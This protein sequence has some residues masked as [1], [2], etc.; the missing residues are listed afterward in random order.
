MNKISKVFAKKYFDLNKAIDK[1]YIDNGIGCLAV[2]IT[3]FNDVISRY[4]G[5]GYECLNYE[6]Y[7]YLDRNIQYIPDNVP[8]LLQVYGCK[9][10]QKQKAIII[11]NVREHYQYKLGE[12][13]ESNNNTVRKNVIFFALAIVFLFLFIALEDNEM[14]SSFLNLVFWFYGSSVVTF[15]AVDVRRARK[16]R[17]RAGQIANMYITIDE[18][19]NSNPITEED[20]RIIYEYLREVE[21]KEQEKN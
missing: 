19:Y 15:F 6:F 9:L 21:A 20:K 1:S 18:K 12:V 10:T 3:K 5:E 2:K 7:S 11:E 13:I 4:S 17:A 8:I 14:I 16:L